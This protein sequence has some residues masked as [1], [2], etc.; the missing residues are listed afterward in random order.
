MTNP[1]QGPASAG[2]ESSQSEFREFIVRRDGARPLSFAGVEMAKATSSGS[3]FVNMTQ[4]S[5]AL[6]RTR[7]GKYVTSLSKAS[8]LTSVLSAISG[9]DEPE[10]STIGKE[11]RKAGVFD[12]FEEAVAWF[13]P[14]RLTDSLRKQLGLDEPERIE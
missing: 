9:D 4:L 14:G 2:P 7:A 1:S 12:T 13:R 5:A 10:P 11:F 6:Y 8:H 3:G